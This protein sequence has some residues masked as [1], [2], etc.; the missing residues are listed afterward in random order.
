ML[1]PPKTLFT[2]KLSYRTFPHLQ[3]KPRSRPQSELWLLQPEISRVTDSAESK[4][5]ASVLYNL[6]VSFLVLK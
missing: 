2:M 1:F 5:L 6:A 3:N 4:S